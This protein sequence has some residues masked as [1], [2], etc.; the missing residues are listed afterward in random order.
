MSTFGSVFSTDETPSSSL[1]RRRGMK[2]SGIF[3]TVLASLVGV[4]LVGTGLAVVMTL[5][6]AKKNAGSLSKPPYGKCGTAAYYAG[7]YSF[8]S[9]SSSAPSTL[10]AGSQTCLFYL[11]CNP[12]EDQ[13]GA[14]AT[15]PELPSSLTSFNKDPG[16]YMFMTK[17]YMTPKMSD[18]SEIDIKHYFVPNGAFLASGQV[19]VF[20]DDVIATKPPFAGIVVWGDA[21]KILTHKDVVEKLNKLGGSYFGQSNA[22]VAG[23]PYIFLYENSGS[24]VKEYANPN[25]GTNIYSNGYNSVI[26][27]AGTDQGSNSTLNP[28]ALITPSSSS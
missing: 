21:S 12:Y 20:L 13:V 22:Y 28:I 16:V 26:N 27:G 7:L 24:Y 25:P 4:A 17:K 2:P 18:A 15:I 5:Y 14:F 3:W 23:S 19:C 10:P 1:V 8:G 6:C 9:S 11:T